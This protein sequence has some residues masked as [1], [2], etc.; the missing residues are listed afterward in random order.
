MVDE[1]VS[2]VQVF[3]P[4][5]HECGT[6]SN[7]LVAWHT[8]FEFTLDFGV[9]LP[10]RQSDDEHRCSSLVASSRGSRSR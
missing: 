1:P 4:S 6:Y 8:P 3:V 2:D 9:T 10:P 7:Y 5:E